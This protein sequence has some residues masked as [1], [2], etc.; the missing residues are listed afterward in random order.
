M[1][2]ACFVGGGGVVSGAGGRGGE[3]VLKSALE[4]RRVDLKQELGV[5]ICKGR[6]VPK[7]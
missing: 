5:A 4:L 3:G 6:T 2:V 1:G 7:D